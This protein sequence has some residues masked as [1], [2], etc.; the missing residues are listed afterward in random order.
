[1]DNLPRVL[2]LKQIEGKAEVPWFFFQKDLGIFKT[3]LNF[4]IAAG[5]LL[6]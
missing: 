6:L 4:G 3:V 5:L 2:F 1:M